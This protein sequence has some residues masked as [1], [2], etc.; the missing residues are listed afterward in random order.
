MENLHTL[1]NKIKMFIGICEQLFTNV[2]SYIHNYKM[3]LQ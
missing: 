2:N 3:S 1:E